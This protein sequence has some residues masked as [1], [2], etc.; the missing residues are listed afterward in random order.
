MKFT[1]VALGAVVALFPLASFILIAIEVAMV[2][3]IAKKHDAVHLGLIVW[4]CTVM[5]PVSFVLKFIAAW[6]HFIPIIGQVSNSAVAAGFIYF[7]YEIADAHF[8]KIGDK[9]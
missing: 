2:F 9:Q 7:V 3:Q 6:L 8:G 1:Y 5:V 4:F